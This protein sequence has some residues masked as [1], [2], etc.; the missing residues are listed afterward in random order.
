MFMRMTNAI[1]TIVQKKKFLFPKYSDFLRLPLH[2]QK[3]KPSHHNLSYVEIFEYLEKSEV[4]TLVQPCINLF[5]FFF[6][7]LCL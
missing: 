6:I 1:D 7:L 4:E 3:E 5:F 2:P